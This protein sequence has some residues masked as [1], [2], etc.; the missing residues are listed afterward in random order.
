MFSKR[1]LLRGDNEESI[2]NLFNTRVLEYYEQRLGM[3][4]E[5]DGVKLIYYRSS[6]RV[7]PDKIQDF[8]QEG[9]DAFTLL[10]TK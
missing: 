3:S 4:M 9:Y 8:L 7:P 5:G 2:R 10:K 6:K 1:Y